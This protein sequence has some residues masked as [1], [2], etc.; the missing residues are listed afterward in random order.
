MSITIKS[1]PSD[2]G[3]EFDVK[4]F[5]I[6]G[7]ELSSPCPKCGHVCVHDLSSDYLSYPT[8]N[9]PMEEGFYCDECGHEWN[10]WIVL[11][12]SVEAAGDK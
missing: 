7:V 10:E 2:Q 6:P 9:V 3:I 8:A 11:R 1:V 5:Y 12:V 4:R